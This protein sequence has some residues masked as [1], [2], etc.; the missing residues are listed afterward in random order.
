[1]AC[2]KKMIFDNL[3]TV[4]V[5]ETTDGGKSNNSN[6]TLQVLQQSGLAGTNVREFSLPILTLVLRVII[7][8]ISGNVSSI[9]LNIAYYLGLD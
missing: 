2:A 7:S 1:M 8:A 5:L 9:V 6:L 4:Q 3:N